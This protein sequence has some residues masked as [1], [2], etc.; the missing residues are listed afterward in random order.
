MEPSFAPRTSCS[1]MISDTMFFWSTTLPD[2]GRTYSPSRLVDR[3]RADPLDVPSATSLVAPQRPSLFI[4]SRRRNR[5]CILPLLSVSRDNRTQPGRDC[6][7]GRISDGWNS[8]VSD[9]FEAFGTRVGMGPW[10]RSSKILDRFIPAG[11]RNRRHRIRRVHNE[12]AAWR[13]GRVVH[14]E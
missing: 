11:R 14:L 6:A 4:G 2:D 10:T 5:Y 1:S 13:M 9:L 3:E 7:G 8:R 12:Q